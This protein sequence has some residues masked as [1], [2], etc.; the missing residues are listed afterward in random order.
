MINYPMFVNLKGITSRGANG[1][2]FSLYIPFH[3]NSAKGELVVILKNPS[4]A[5]AANSDRTVTRVCNV[6]YHNGY[7]GV[8]ILNLLPYRSTQA[9]GVRNFYQ[10]KNYNSI[11]SIN[12]KLIISS[13]QMR[14]VVFAWGTD[15]V[16]GRRSYPNYYDDAIKSVTSSVGFNTYYVMSCN[17]GNVICNNSHDLIRYPLHGLRWKNNALLIAY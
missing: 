1:F 5:T 10:N 17:C 13:C 8:I 3:C 7:S 15:T 9:S 16:K 2:R 11:M 6:A 14:D 12:L 4:Q